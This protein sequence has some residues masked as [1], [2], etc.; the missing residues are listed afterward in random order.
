MPGTFEGKK[1]LSESFLRRAIQGLLIESRERKVLRAPFG[2]PIQPSPLLNL[3]EFLNCGGL[4]EPSDGSVNDDPVFSYDYG[5]DP[6]QYLADYLKFLHPSNIKRMKD[7]RNKIAERLHFR[8]AHANNVLDNFDKL[9]VL[10]LKLSSGILWGPFTSPLT[11]ASS[12][13][14][15]VVCA[16]RVIR[17]GDLLVQISQDSSFN[18]IEKTVTQKVTDKAVTQKI[19]ISDLEAGATYYMR[20]CLSD[21]VIQSPTPELGSRA[22]VQPIINSTDAAVAVV[23]DTRAFRGTS[24]G[25]FQYTQFVACPSDEDRIDDDQQIEIDAVTVVALNVSSAHM[26]AKSLIRQGTSPNGYFISCLLG[27]VFPNV[28]SSEIE[29]FSVL[30]DSAENSNENELNLFDKAN[31]HLHRFSD[32]FVSPESVLRNSSM[33]L[34]WHDRSADSDLQ[35]NEEELALKQF[36]SDMK[37]Y[38]TKFGK[39]KGGKHKQRSPGSGPEVTPP[40]PKLRREQITPQLEA[41][42]QV[43]TAL[44]Y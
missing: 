6:L 30:P 36:T 18:Q 1:A 35:L 24:E 16:C 33:L 41:V 10:T 13:S 28:V 4:E 43:R 37:K 38:Q 11:S 42:L 5:F 23:E 40:P 22:L 34:A 14:I 27:E 7:E 31:F 29:E 9:K 26:T 21:S 3:S 44:Q 17:V 15:A 12:S 2:R 39:G 19:I 32:P 20:C 8:A 25:L